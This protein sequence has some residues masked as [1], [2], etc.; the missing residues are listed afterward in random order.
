MNKKY[1]KIA[2]DILAEIASYQEEKDKVDGLVSLDK[3]GNKEQ[4][5]IVSDSTVDTEQ[6]YMVLLSE[7]SLLYND[8]TIR[9]YITKGTIEKW[10]NSIDDSFEGYVTTGHV[11]T[12]SNPIREGY[13]TKENLKIVN[14]KDGRVDLLVKP[15]VNLELSNVKDL[16]IQNEPFAISAELLAYPASEDVMKS[17]EYEILSLYNQAKGGSEEVSVTDTIEIQGFSFVGNPGNARSGGYLPQVLVSNE[18]ERI[19]KLD[20]NNILDKLLLKLSQE[21]EKETVEEQVEQPQEEKV[22]EEAKQEEAQAEQTPEEDV[23]AKATEKIEQ[24]QKEL[25]VVTAERD[26]LREFKKEALSAQEA[27]NTKLEKLAVLLDKV[28]PEVEQPVEKVQSEERKGLFPN[29]RFN[30]TREV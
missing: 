22:E 6:G 17:D 12:D 3:K 7:G 9:L 14:N 5:S 8:G 26:E 23:L 28:N 19:Q 18:K 10:Y 29:G 25:E 13:F 2:R 15:V 24:L 11:S 21:E 16:I 20:K 1:T 4:L 27:Q 30:Y